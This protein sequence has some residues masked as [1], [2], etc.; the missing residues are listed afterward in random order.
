MVAS[1]LLNLLSGV[2]GTDLCQQFVIPEIVSLAED[3]VFRVRKA[4]ALSFHNICKVGG[5]HELFERLMP[6]YVRLSKDDMY[7]VRKAV[8]QSLSDVSKNVSND[9]RLGVLIEI[10]LR[11]AQ[12]PSRQVRQCVLQEAGMF[13]ATLPPRATNGMVMTHYLSM[14]DGPTGDLNVDSELKHYCAFC[15]PGVLQTIGG[16]RWPEMKEIYHKLVQSRNAAVKQTLSLSLHEIARIL[17]EGGISVDEELLPV[18]EDMIQDVESV[19]LGVI[20]NIAKFLALLS[21]PCRTSYLPLLHD[22]LHSTSPFNWRMRQHLALQLSDLLLLPQRSS[23]CVTLFPLIMALLQDPVACVR[24]ASF[25]GVARLILLLDELVHSP[26]A[27]KEISE[28]DPN[29]S[30][31][32]EVVAF[33]IDCL[34]SFIQNVNLFVYGEVY[35]KRLLWLELAH[36]LLKLIPRRLFELFFLEGIIIL[37]NDPVCNVRVVVSEA[38]AGFEPEFVSP[39]LEEISAPDT[40]DVSITHSKPATNPYIWLLKREDIRECVKRLVA[41]DRDV[42][43]NMNKLQNLFPDLE[44]RPRS[45]RG[46]KAAPGGSHHVN[47][48]KTKSQLELSVYQQHFISI[49]AMGL[50]QGVSSDAEESDCDVSVSDN[51]IEYRK[52]GSFSIKLNTS[53]S[54]GILENALTIPMGSPI[55]IDASSAA[56][57]R[58]RSPITPPNTGKGAFFEVEAKACG[59]GDATTSGDFKALEESA[60][61][62]NGNRDNAKPNSPFWAQVD[63]L[64]STLGDVEP[65]EII[66]VS[67]VVKVHKNFPFDD[68]DDDECGENI[69]PAPEGTV[70]VGLDAEQG[71]L[72]EESVESD[73]EILSESHGENAAEVTVEGSVDD[74]NESSEQ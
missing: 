61:D 65:L 40:Y 71:G 72:N 3:P 33:A 16:A 31:P 38:L 30:T 25:S 73:A 1:E 34:C 50:E 18:F 5:E 44:F 4:A 41:D 39:T 21:P 7:R 74:E 64:S 14:A 9:I 11:L 46:M 68:E 6:A 8:A 37:A 59:N 17:H 56:F 19:Q 58:D 70:V 23:M 36:A 51:D 20:K 27:A 22:F 32:E 53:N 60:N 52:S 54:T 66:H 28:Q 63:D 29:H 55:E 12:D 48:I 26:S 69:L 15:F 57:L 24:H 67:G 10:F 49:G 47:M 42:Y 45:C 2:L 35:Q 13:I 62:S 43:V